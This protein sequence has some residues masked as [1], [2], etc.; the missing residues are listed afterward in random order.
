MEEQ[1]LLHLTLPGYVSGSS[2]CS[3]D[4]QKGGVCIF[5][6]KD[7][8]ANKIDISH[9]CIEKDLEIC[10]VELETEASKLIILSLYRAPTGDFDQFIKNLDNILEYL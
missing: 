4:L 1:D 2:F 6:C 9:R 3:K 10:A 5:V 8:N 7:L